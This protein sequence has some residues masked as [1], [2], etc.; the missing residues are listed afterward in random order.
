M[1]KT[2]TNHVANATQLCLGW[3]EES[4]RGFS[5]SGRGTEE[6]KP[7]VRTPGER[8][9]RDCSKR[10]NGESATE[11]VQLWLLE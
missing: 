8:V 10:R 3:P 11:D 9:R 7:K 4:Y 1:S 2:V 6:P 5:E